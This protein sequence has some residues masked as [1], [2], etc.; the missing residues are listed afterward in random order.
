MGAGDIVVYD[1]ILGSNIPRAEKSFISRWFDQMIERNDGPSYGGRSEGV[2]TT[3]IQAVRGSGEG[4]VVGGLLAAAH[5]ALP[6]GLD[7]HV[8]FI[9]KMVPLDA[10]AG[11]AANVIAVGTSGR[12]ISRD[13]ANIGVASFG[14]FTFRKLCDLLGEKSLNKAAPGGATARMHGEEDPIVAAARAL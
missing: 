7:V 14:V 1:S 6:T 3:G 11:I 13:A 5:A 12:E 2:V 8:P 10:A 4:M 9:D